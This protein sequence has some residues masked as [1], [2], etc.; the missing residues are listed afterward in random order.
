[1][2]KN[3]FDIRIK[4]VGDTDIGYM[5]WRNQ[6]GQRSY[7]VEDT[8]T[9]AP[10]L[11][12]QEQLS[13]S[14]LPPDIALTFPQTNWR[15]GIG[16]IRFQA[17][18]LD[19][20]ADATR[21]DV[22][23]QGKIKLARKTSATT[24][25]ETPDTYD[26]S[27]FT[28]SGEDV[29]SFIGQ[30][31]YKW[32]FS[33]KR[34]DRQDEPVAAARI[35]RNAVNFEGTLY[36]PAWADDAG[37]G[38]S[39]TAVDE[40]CNYIYKTASDTTFVAVANTTQTLDGCKYMAVADQKLWG[41]YW[42]DSPD[43]GVELLTQNVVSYDATSTGSAVT[44]STITVSHECS[45]SNRALIVG[46]S[47]GS[48]VS[49][50]RRIPSGVTYNGISMTSV[51]S[52]TNGGIAVSIWQLVAPATG[53]NDIVA[54]FAA[55]FSDCVLGA[56]SFANVNQSTPVG[57]AV[58]D[59]GAGTGI[60]ET[61]SSGNFA[62][63]VACLDAS[64]DPT[65]GSDQT[66]RWDTG[67]S[68][69]IIRG[70]GSTEPRTT[71]STTTMSWSWSGSTTF[72]YMT[73]P[74]N[75]I[76][77]TNSATTIYTSATP[78]SQFAAADVIR[79]ESELMLVS[80]VDDSGPSLTVVR[81]Y[82]GSVAILHESPLNIHEVTEKPHQVRSA[83]DGTAL[84]NWST[85]TSVGDSSAAITALVGVGS[86]LIVI[87]TDGIYR[88]ETDGTV[89]N[90]RP[91]LSA[92]AH[93]DF[94]K[95]AWA[96]NDL[97]FI[98]LHG[99]GLW[100]LETA[101]WTVRDVSF[102]I[103]MPEETQYHGQVV[104]GHGE[105]NKLYVLV[106]EAGNTQ[107]HVMMT[108]NPA[109]AGIDDYNWTVATI[110]G[111]TTGTDTNHA[112][113]LLEAVTNG[114]NEHHRLLIGIRSTGSNLM[115]YFMPHDS[116]DLAAEFATTAG[117][118]DTV[119][120]D[121]GFPNVSKRAQDITINAT[122]LETQ[123][124]TGIDTDEALNDTDTVIDL[125]ANPTNK[126]GVDDIVT[127]DDEK[128][129]V[130]AI[131]ASPARI[132]VTRGYAGTEAVG[133]DNNRDIDFTHYIYV[134]Y[135]IDGGALTYVTGSQST[136]TL[137]SNNQTLAF[138]QG[139]TFKRISFKF[140]MQRL[141]K[142]VTTLIGDSAVASPELHDF[143]FTCQLRPTAVKQLPLA[144]YIAN[145][146]KLNN[147]TIENKGKTKRDQL[148]TWNTQAAEVVVTDIENG[149][150]NCVFLPGQMRETEMFE[151][152]H[153]FPQYRVDVVLAEVG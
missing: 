132:T 142:T 130:T 86:N 150:R 114:S 147:G 37:S 9:I 146:I 16:G 5:L 79:V 128:M 41:G 51:G 110:I 2:P 123:V 135:Q 122:D 103:S 117:V 67:T 29:W 22:S 19:V 74:I 96:W 48:A 108:E 95:G 21:M 71:E 89:T 47:A 49:G 12:T 141:G 3:P 52:S 129:L 27:G 138:A 93:K 106:H 97:I 65:V 10:R 43:S 140:T 70:F 40:P 88:L 104:A 134:Q 87:K 75:A 131:S 90:L 99:G 7:T 11:L 61:L 115:P 84:G 26:A 38:G 116:H 100:E 111:Y 72:A 73:V 121:G 94:G 148:R 137:T 62:F 58:S 124:G 77:V 125:D 24:T 118:A 53:A 34:W 59:T 32:D 69:G 145:G 30:D 144:L 151:S 13:Q 28:V 20:L 101:T 31:V 33:N 139:I 102:S 35:Y 46:V 149:T 105:P 92:L 119:D 68:N 39:Y 4:T 85:A 112:A 120:F 80:A 63:D 25:I 153:G 42:A 56:A 66:E 23:S 50:V 54:T 78:S 109:S 15:R 55:N 17:Q 1:M 143:T 82:R 133:H 136:S 57:T 126:I 64:N 127:I 91:E 76:T 45:G 36:A 14:Q 8:Q 60:S 81:G 18:D 113:M 83:A 107:Y 152:Y 44:A 6:N 98:P